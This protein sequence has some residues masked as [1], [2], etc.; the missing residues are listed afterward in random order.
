MIRYL[1][2]KLLIYFLTFFVMVTINWIV[3]RLMPGDPINHILA[4]FARSTETFESMKKY[5]QG[6]YGLD[7]PL[8]QQYLS[9]W[10]N[11]LHGNLGTSLRYT[12]RSVVDVLAEALPYTLAVLFPAILISWILGNWFGAYAARR[13]V[14]DNYILPISYIFMSAPYFWLGLVMVWFFSFVLGVF[15]I[16]FA[17]NPGIVPGW[18]LT[19]ILDFLWHWILPTLSLVLVAFGG[20][21]IGMRN[22]IIYE[23]ESNYSHY[24]ESLGASNQLIRSYAYRNAILPQVTGLAIQ[25]GTLIAG[26]IL[27]ETVFSYPGIGYRLF[28]AVRNQDYFLI[29]GGFICVIT[30]VLIF[31]FLIDVIYMFIDPRIRSCAYGGAQ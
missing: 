7:K 24:M 9:F 26:N 29:Q 23:L 22:L 10:N 16:S 18:N 1:R 21:A 17:Y 4:R 3:P 2:K 28:V 12:P 11:L 6:L 30:L 27:L 14:L 5:I 15:P 19:F 8:L 31:N 13:K 25:M 20:W